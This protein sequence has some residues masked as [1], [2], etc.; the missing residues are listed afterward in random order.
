MNL[1]NQID[2]PFLL[3][4][5]TKLIVILILI[6]FIIEIFSLDKLVA[7]HIYQ[8]EGNQWSLKNEWATAVLI[9]LGGKYFSISMLLIT[10]MLLLA[11][12]TLPALKPWKYRLLYL[13]TATLSGS[14]FVSIGKSFSDI[15]CPWDFDRYGGTL[16]Y[17]SLL[18][19]LWLRNGSHCFP[20]GHASAG[21]AWVAL[22]FV[23]LHSNSIW[24]RWALGFALLL[25]CIF[26]ISQQL[27]GA[28]FLSHDIW[29]FGFC[30][31]VSLICYAVMLKP[32]ELT[33]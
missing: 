20:A 3:I 19:Q 6:T 31:M 5:L 8:W 30:W 32:Y 17:T 10:L 21:F 12:Y 9:H 11:S 2:K 4:S 15:S 22:Y 33:K 27:R 28:H 18:E 23:G 24:R 1:K 7:D 14:I 16:E 13:V 29:S 26:G 25:G